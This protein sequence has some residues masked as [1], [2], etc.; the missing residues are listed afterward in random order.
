MKWTMTSVLDKLSIKSET[1]TGY[2]V[3][4]DDLESAISIHNDTIYKNVRRHAVNDITNQFLSIMVTA[5]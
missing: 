1:I 3:E 2:S 4:V 5:N